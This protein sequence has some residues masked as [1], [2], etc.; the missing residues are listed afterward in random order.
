MDEWQYE[1]EPQHGLN[2]RDLR[3]PRM[4]VNE[5]ESKPQ[6][7]LNTRDLRA[8][9]MNVNM[10]RYARMNKMNKIKDRGWR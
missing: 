10:M 6:H 7:S 2:T 4:N 5:Y 3:V 1:S 8:S 9:R